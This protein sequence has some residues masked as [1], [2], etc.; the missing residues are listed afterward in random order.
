L[1]SG[2]TSLEAFTAVFFSLFEKESETLGSEP[3]G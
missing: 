2:L 1:V 3:V